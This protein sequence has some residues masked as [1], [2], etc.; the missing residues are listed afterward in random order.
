MFDYKNLYGFAQHFHP[1]FKS[2]RPF[3][4][5]V[6]DNFLSKALLEMAVTSFPDPTSDFWRKTENEHT[7]NKL[8]PNGYF[9]TQILKELRYTEPMRRLFFELNCG[10]FMWFLNLLTNITLT[11]DPFYIEGGFH[12]VGDKGKLD[13]HADF[14]HHSALKLERRLNLLLYLNADW[15]EEYGGGLHLYD[16]DLTPTDPIWP[17]MNRCVIFETSPTSF[18]GHPEPMNLPAGV[19]R[20]SLALY[21]YALPRPERADE[22]AIFPAKT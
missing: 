1:Q 16:K 6:I 13:I 20:K 7:V 18:H 17:V 11:S 12:C 9:G 2:A 10:P 4:Y 21:Y 14:S 15:K 5:I 22:R 19:W 8:T 3:P